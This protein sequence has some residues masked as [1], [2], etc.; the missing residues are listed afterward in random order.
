VT[1][2]FCCSLHLYPTIQPSS[3]SIFFDYIHNFA[4]ATTN[5]QVIWLD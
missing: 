4:V 3:G 5:R 2:R 1:N